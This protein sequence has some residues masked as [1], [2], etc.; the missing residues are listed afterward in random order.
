MPWRLK[1]DLARFRS[2][3]M[4]KPVVMG[5]KTYVSIGK[6]LAGRTTIVASRDSGLAIPGAIAVASLAQALAVARGDA[7]R[8][9]VREIIVAGGADIYA[10]AMPLADRLEITHV[11]ARPDGDTVFPPIDAAIWQEVTRAAPPESADGPAFTF[12]TYGRRAGATGAA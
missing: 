7:L 9:G 10:Q 11:D 3:T 4:G 6:P 5:R 12:V 2:L 8:R 1:A